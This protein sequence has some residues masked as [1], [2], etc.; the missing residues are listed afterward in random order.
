MSKEAEIQKLKQIAIDRY[1]G[2]GGV[3]RECTDDQGYIALI[4]EHGTAER[5]WESHMEILAIQE[6][7]YGYFEFY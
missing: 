2:D 4:D 3:M 6:E 5:A 7:N 1:V